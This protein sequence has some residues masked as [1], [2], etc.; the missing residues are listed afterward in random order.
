MQKILIAALS[1][2][3]FIARHETETSTKWTS[4]E[5][6]QWFSRKTKE[7]GV[8]IMGRTT[9]ETIGRPLPQRISYV[10]SKS[11]QPITEAPET[12]LSEEGSVFVTSSDPAA[13]L[14][15]LERRDVERVAICGGSTI[16]NQFLK[17]GLVD[18]L[19]L[20]IEP[21][22]FGRGISLSSDQLDVRLQLVQLHPLSEHTIVL[23][24]SASTVR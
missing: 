5:D 7:I 1:A 23:E 6:A 10:L 18:R 8:C 20:T 19:F 22:L 14:A 17:L 2:D 4:K 12:K 11:G 21:V 16:Y 24:Y 13:V 15:E 9:Y 3:G